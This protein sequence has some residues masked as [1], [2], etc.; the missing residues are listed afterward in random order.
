MESTEQKT[1][2]RRFKRHKVNRR[3]IAILGPDPVRVGH[4]TIISEEAVEILFSENNGKTATKFSELVVLVSDC[5][6]SFLSEK[7][8]IETVSCSAAPINGNRV[9]SRM[10]KCV[11]SLNNM[12]FIKKRQLQSAC[13]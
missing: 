4:V 8:H 10:R 13:L 11:I 7:I 9:S 1:E 6:S 12:N 3:P 5:I 2:R